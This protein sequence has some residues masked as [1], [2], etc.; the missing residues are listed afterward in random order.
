MFSTDVK[1]MR[2]IN[3]FF[4]TPFYSNSSKKKTNSYY[5][6][7]P[8]NKKGC[9]QENELMLFNISDWINF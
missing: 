4:Q 8:K 7:N 1:I 6:Y 3:I 9:N 5:K 2:L